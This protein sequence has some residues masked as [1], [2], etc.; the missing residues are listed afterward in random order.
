MTM[1]EKKEFNFNAIDSLIIIALCFAIFVFIFCLL[2]NDF[3]EFTSPKHEIAYILSIDNIYSSQ[4][5]NGND[6]LTSNGKKIGQITNISSATEA[7]ISVSATAYEVDG[8]L[9]IKGNKIA[10]GESF[11]LVLENGDVVPAKCLTVYDR[12]K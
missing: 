6:L 10:W 5:E 2:G 1:N 12:N 7:H 11:E 4:F 8:V 3:A 9:F